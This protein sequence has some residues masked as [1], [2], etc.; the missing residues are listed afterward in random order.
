MDF[1]KMPMDVKSA[2]AMNV[3][4]SNAECTVIMDFRKMTMDVKSVNVMIV[5]KHVA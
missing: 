5:H 3:H 1:R 4:N 2:N